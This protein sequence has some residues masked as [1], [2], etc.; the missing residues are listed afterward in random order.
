[1][2]E[3]YGWAEFVAPSSLPDEGAAQAYFGAAGGLLAVAWLL[4]A[5]DLHMDNVVATAAG[6]VVVDAEAV[7]HEALQ[8]QEHLLTQ[9]QELQR[10]IATLC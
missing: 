9:D 4:G 7:L 2:R 1:V 10:L 3:E 6:P 8:I 5:R